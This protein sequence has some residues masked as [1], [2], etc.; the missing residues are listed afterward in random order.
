MDEHTPTP[1]ET[2]EIE[3]RLA[4]QQEADT[5]PV[6]DDEVGTAFGLAERY[7]ETVDFGQ[8]LAREIEDHSDDLPTVAPGKFQTAVRR[9]ADVVGEPA[10]ADD[11]H[12]RLRRVA[13]ADAGEWAYAYESLLVEATDDPE[14]AFM[15][16]YPAESALIPVVVTVAGPAERAYAHFGQCLDTLTETVDRRGRDR[17]E[18]MCDGGE[19]LCF[20]CEDSVAEYEV[21]PFGYCEACLVEWAET[22][23]RGEETIRDAGHGDVL[24]RNGFGDDP[25][26]VGGDSGSTR[27]IAHPVSLAQTTVVERVADQGWEFQG[28]RFAHAPDTQEVWDRTEE[29]IHKAV[30]HDDK[31]VVTVPTGGG[32]SYAA[33]TTDWGLRDDLTDGRQVVIFHGTREARDDA[34]Q[35]ARDH[36]TD[37]LVLKSRDEL[38]PLASGE[39]DPDGEAD[40]VLTVDGE[41]VSEFI[42]RQCDEKGVPF[43]NVH[44]YVHENNDQD[45]TPKC[46]AGQACPAQRQHEQRREG[47]HDLVIACDN[48]AHV[49][50]LRYGK[51]I[52]M[53]E[54]PSF[55]EGLSHDRVRDAVEAYLH[56]VDAPL[57]TLG[58]LLRAA[59]QED[60]N[61]MTAGPL[62][63][64]RD[65]VDNTP[66]RD[67]F[68]EE[69]DAHVLAPGIIQALL[70]GDEQGPPGYLHGK[71]GYEPPRLDAGATDSDMWNVVWV[72][73]T[74]NREDEITT[75]RATPDFNQSSSLVGL[76]AHP[77]IEQW[78]LNTWPDLHPTHTLRT[79]ERQLWR[80]HERGL[81]TV[82]VG[83]A[84]R[85]LT[86]E[87]YHDPHGSAA[88]VEEI[89]DTHGDDFRTAITSLA[90]EGYV[91]DDL[92]MAGVDDP[93]TMH[94]GNVKSRND[95]ADENVGL[96]QGCIDP[97]D[98][99]VLSLLAEIDA[100]AEPERG[101]VC[102]AQCG[103]RDAAPEEPGDG[104]AECAG[105]GMAREHGRGFVGEDAD[106]AKAILDSVRSSLVAQA[107][108]RWARD[109]TDPDD[110]AIV[111]VRTSVAP[112]HMIDAYAPGVEWVY[113][114]KQRQIAEYLRDHETATARDV[115]EAVDCSKQHALETL[116]E[117]ENRG[118]ATA[119]AG[120]GKYGATVWASDNVPTTGTASL[121]ETTNQDVTSSYNVSVGGLLIVDAA[122]E[123]VRL[124][125]AD[126]D[127]TVAGAAET[128]TADAVA[129]GGGG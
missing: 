54:M 91:A 74:A 86:D 126:G 30:L 104:C 36:G 1:P 62:E 10:A 24:D 96:V 17:P 5:I 23:D 50:A 38:C 52:I 25:D 31:T 37:P 117:L 69:P 45:A 60:R 66:D 65:A 29:A 57:S 51:H 105:T 12:A 122:D 15:L 83:D 59:R 61:E 114:D 11:D 97:G 55:R 79:E 6:G 85:P 41:K 127:E 63:A 103:D 67:W 20:D 21:G 13:A 53:D 94:Y 34:A 106:R 108:G 4:R 43:S 93:M 70:N 35:K 76:D 109:A 92:R 123:P 14:Y 113:G 71:T 116:S 7:D 9:F 88:L 26:R 3:A 19:D 75:V 77:E 73:V 78:R 90:V 111:Y 112:D 107:I 128:S 121:Y 18:V 40:Q 64:T 102:C 119:E 118:L 22:E 100:E 27:D 124:P 125:W 87:R 28:G 89:R 110:T 42:H 99:F 68:I 32:K 58:G 95:F 72:G 47:D 48:F 98:E 56:R 33:A 46:S 8:L 115:A 101:D 120:A 81:R 44:R 39:C 129:G 84:E 16:G 82:Q 49:P 2:G 80:R